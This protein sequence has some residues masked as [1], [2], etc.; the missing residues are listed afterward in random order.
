[1]RGPLLVGSVLP[2]DSSNLDQ[3]VKEL[4]QA[5]LDRVQWDAIDGHLVP[6]L[7]FGPDIIAA[8]CPDVTVDSQAHLIVEDPDRMLSRCCEGL[9]IRGWKVASSRSSE[10]SERYT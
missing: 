9:A 7:T 10:T 1:M 2:A 8:N 5:G 6:N 4:Q 3:Q